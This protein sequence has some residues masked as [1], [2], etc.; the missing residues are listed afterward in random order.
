VDIIVPVRNEEATIDELYERVA[1]LGLGDRLL[2]VDNESTDRTVDRIRAHPAVRLIEHTSNEGYGGSILDGIAQSDA[3][4][5]IIL[6]ADL[7]Y[8][9]EAITVILAALEHH[10]A[11]H[12]SRFLGTEP[13]AMPVV[14]RV[15]NRMM[16]WLFNVLFGQRTTDLCTGMKGLRRSMLPLSRLRRRGFEHAIELAVV[17]A[18]SGHQIHDVPVVY[19]PRFRGRSKMRHLPV[20]LKL[21]S[22]LF[23][24]RMREPDR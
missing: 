5:V 19:R 10:P 2:F 24:Y 21:V 12:A 6:D 3:E 16:S 17:V 7:E 9:P 4:H 15:G 11:V 14:R 8:P 22:Y 20:A 18:R 1:R 13:P 23:L